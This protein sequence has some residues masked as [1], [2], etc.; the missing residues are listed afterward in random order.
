MEHHMLL[1]YAHLLL[2]AYWLA[3][4]WGVYV[5]SAYVARADL[6]IAERRRFLQAALRID[7]VPRSCL[8]LLLPLGLQLATNLSL[9]PLQGLPMILIWMFGVAWLLVSWTIHRQHATVLGHRLRR[10]DHGFRLVLSL[11]LIG[12]GL[13]SLISDDG[14]PVAW[15]ATKLIGFGLLLLL[16]LLL[17]RVMGGW[18]TGF[19]RLEDE[20]STPQ[21]EAIFAGALKRAKPIVYLFWMT[22][23]GMAALGFLKPF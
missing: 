1:V 10:I 19:A 4:D 20:G 9:V 22:S 3:P 7:L 14:I 8:I 17:R 11:G 18:A 5:N 2:F 12:W 6:P 15:L 21:T 16:G 23:A 13:W